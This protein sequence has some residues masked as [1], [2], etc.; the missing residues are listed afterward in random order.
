VTA[1]PFLEPMNLDGGCD[2]GRRQT[3]ADHRHTRWLRN[4][5]HERLF[6]T[7][8]PTWW[9]SLK[10]PIVRLRPAVEEPSESAEIGLGSALIV[11]NGWR[12]AAARRTAPRRLNRRPARAAGP[13][14]PSVTKLGWRDAG[15][16]LECMPKGREVAEPQGRRE[17]ADAEER[18]VQ[19]VAGQRLSHP[20][21]QRLV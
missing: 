6:E 3:A 20:V 5:L 10:G 14:R 8:I 15:P 21:Q 17:I 12:S 7:T 19:V 16:A 18:V 11:I 9:M 2:A 1:R 13:P 4:A